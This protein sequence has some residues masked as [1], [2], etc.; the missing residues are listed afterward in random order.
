MEDFRDA[1][2]RGKYCVVDDRTHFKLPNRIFLSIYL[3]TTIKEIIL[4]V[5]CVKR[6]KIME[7]KLKL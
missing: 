7:K 2:L 3:K 1:V 4:S 5:W 6:G